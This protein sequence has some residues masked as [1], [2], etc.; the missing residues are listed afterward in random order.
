MNTILHV[1]GLRKTFKLS[2]KQ[3]K[4]EKTKDKVKVAVKGISFEAYQGEIFG[5]LGPNGAGKTTT[6]RMLSTLIKPDEGDAFVDGFSIVSQP[7]HVRARIG[8][9]TSELKLEDYFTPNYLFDFFSELHDVPK[10]IRDERKKAMFERFGIDQFAEVK[11]ANL[12][13]GMKQ[14][15]SLVISIVH[16]PDIIIFDEPTNGLDI[17]TA[18]VVTDFLI[19][20]KNSGKSIIVSTHIFSLVEKICDRVGIIINGELVICQKL[21]EFLNGMSLEDRF[22]QLYEEK[23]G[24]LHE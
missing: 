17:L 20:L 8:F 15:V 7:E 11:I 5:L 1:E 24:E 3:Q 23:A 12:S 4:I 16:D 13:T 14:K 22:F 10:D 19:E 21:K 6:L 9:L 18:K 2:K